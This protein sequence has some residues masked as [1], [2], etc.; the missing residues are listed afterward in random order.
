MTLQRMEHV[1][2]VVENLAEAIAFFSALGL[3]PQ[4]QATVA[5]PVVDRI[6]GLEGVRNEVAM[7]QTP[8]GDGRLELIEFH[9]PELEPGDQQAPANTA[10]LRHIA[11]AVQDIEAVVADLQQHGARLVGEIETYEGAYRLC[12]LRGP[13]G[14]IVELAEQVG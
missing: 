11:F 10:G 6:V 5:S 1:G 14:V 7:L 12:Y 13:A 4:G 8:D 9:A 2:I 3:E